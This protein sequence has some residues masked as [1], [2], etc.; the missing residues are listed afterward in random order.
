MKKNEE[1]IMKYSKKDK[2]EL[3]KQMVTNWKI[4]IKA[5][6]ER[7]KHLKEEIKE[8]GLSIRYER[9][10]LKLREEMFE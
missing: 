1:I 9:H 5:L 10:A 6:E 4:H 8:L 2:P 3:Y 7:R